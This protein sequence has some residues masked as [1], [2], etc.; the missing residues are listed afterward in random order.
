MKKIY[1]L[2]AVTFLVVAALVSGCADH[3]QELREKAP[4]II[5]SKLNEHIEENS[6][7]L[8]F[9]TADN[10]IFT[11]STGEIF[12]DLNERNFYQHKTVSF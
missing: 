12:N 2:F 3:E 8:H 6:S 10:E 11:I 1:A 9:K 7:A 4:N 5:I